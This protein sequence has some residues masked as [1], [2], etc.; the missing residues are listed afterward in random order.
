MTA[1]GV[2]SAVV[3][4]EATGGL[5]PCGKDT[6][7]DEK[8]DSACTICNFI[9]GIHEIIKFIVSL[10]AA[11]ATVVIVVAGIMY[12]ISAGNPAMT[13][14]AKTAMKNALIGVIVVLTAFMMITFVANRM[15]GATGNGLGGSAWNI[16]C[17]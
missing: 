2:P 4:A 3:H 1:V 6:G 16:D 8:K 12:I 13:S 15:L 11:T 14:I 7:T 5:V 17:Q 9:D 10:I